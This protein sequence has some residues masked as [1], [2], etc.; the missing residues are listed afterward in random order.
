[1]KITRRQLK[2]LISEE[3]NLNESKGELNEMLPAVAAAGH[4][5]VGAAGGE[6]MLAGAATAIYASLAAILA[7]SAVWML[8]PDGDKD[9]ITGLITKENLEAAFGIYL[10]LKGAGTD[11]DAINQLL[12]V[13]DIPK[14]S[15]DFEQVLRM[16][17]EDTDK[18]LQQW[19]RDDGMTGAANTVQ[20][21]I[22][23]FLRAYTRR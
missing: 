20:D 18:D 1:M 4:C 9:R 12:S 16:M 10:S 2:A 21:T 13:E 22:E 6:A 15:A 19:L 7:G 11:E 8:M 5:R 17:G 14:I 23:L 3:L